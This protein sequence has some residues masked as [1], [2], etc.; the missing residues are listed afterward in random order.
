MKVALSVIWLF[1]I[2]ISVL[3]DVADAAVGLLAL[4]DEHA[5]RISTTADAITTTNVFAIF[6]FIDTSKTFDVS[7]IPAHYEDLMKM[8]KLLLFDWQ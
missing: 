8:K 2:V 5:P 6:G 4:F 3:P 7:I 1:V